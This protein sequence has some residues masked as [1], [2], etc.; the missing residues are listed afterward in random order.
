MGLV[1]PSSTLT[2]IVTTTLRNRTGVLA[3]NV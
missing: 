1:N 2:E 3:D